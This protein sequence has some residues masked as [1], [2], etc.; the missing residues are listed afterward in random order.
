MRTQSHLLLATALFVPSMA[1]ASGGPAALTIDNKFDGEAEVVVDGHLEG[2]ARPNAQTTFSVRPGVSE[3]KVTRPGTHFVLADTRL[4]LGSH[5]STTLPVLA[6]MGSVRVQNQGDVALKL[7]VGA[8]SVW[9]QPGAVTLLPVKTGNVELDASIHDP[10]GDWRAIERPLWVEPGQVSTTTLKPDPTVIVVANREAM[11]IRALLDGKDAGWIQPGDRQRMWVR[12]G[13]T[14]VV[15]LDRA[16]RVL[17]TTPVF[18]TRGD[19]AKVVVTSPV[20]AVI[21]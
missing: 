5:T 19:D 7:E 8:N 11:P 2:I 16:G 10:R 13:N 18:V 17:S 1:L 20:V 21:R 4:L 15:L 3:V 12:P 6:P 14:N 9:L